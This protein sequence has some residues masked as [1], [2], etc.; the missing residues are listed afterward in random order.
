MEFT[1]PKPKINSNDDIPHS[2]SN[3]RSSKGGDTER[4]N[5]GKKKGTGS[6]KKP[7]SKDEVESKPVRFSEDGDDENIVKP[8]QEDSEDEGVDKDDKKGTKRKRKPV[9]DLR[10]EELKGRPKGLKRKERK[11]KYLEAKKKKQNKGKPED[12]M[13]GFQGHE[14]IRFGDVVEAPPKLNT[15][16]KTSKP[17]QPVQAAFQERL[18]LQAVEA[19]RSRKKWGSRPGLQI[20]AAEIPHTV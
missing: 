8:K 19:Y 2:E 17:V 14:K 15:V 18:R 9:N 13:L 4:G 6:D 11:K 5:K 1:S 16:P 20:P 3:P 12:D 7:T 10:F